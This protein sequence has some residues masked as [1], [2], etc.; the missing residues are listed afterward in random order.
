MFFIRSDNDEYIRNGFLTL[1]HVIDRQYMR[2][3]EV[4]GNYDLV[5]NSMPNLEVGTSDSYRINYF[6]TLL[7]ILFSTLLLS[8]FIVPFVEEKQ[9]GLKEYLNLVTPMSF[10]NGLTF[11]L[12][13]FLCYVTFLVVTLMFAWKYGALGL[14]GFLY[15]L[16]LYVLYIIASMSYAYLISVCFNTGKFKP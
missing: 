14:V 1:Q 16:P 12:I 10:F 4:N 8:T 2:Y 7:S 11:F 15:I 9:N 13:R 3:Q 6:G 5:L